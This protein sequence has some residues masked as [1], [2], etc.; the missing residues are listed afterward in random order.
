MISIGSSNKMGVRSR[1]KVGLW[2]MGQ[3]GYQKHQNKRINFWMFDG[4]K[5]FQHLS[6]VEG[7]Q[8]NRAEPSFEKSGIVP[9]SLRTI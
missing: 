9:F 8:A 5:N 4:L 7:D 1:Q 3:F 2:I 6:S